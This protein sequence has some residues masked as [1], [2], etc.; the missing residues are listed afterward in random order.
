M[1]SLL[2]HDVY[3]R[4]PGES[5]FNSPAADRYKLTVDEFDAQLR[6]LQRVVAPQAFLVTVDDG[7]ESYLTLVADRLEAV[8]LA[9]WGQ[10]PVRKYSKG[11][12]QRAGIAQASNARH[13]RELKLV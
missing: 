1:V 3:V 11:M 8:G 5:G 7:G 2:F 9:E 6:G 4:E 10:T 13:A 12:L